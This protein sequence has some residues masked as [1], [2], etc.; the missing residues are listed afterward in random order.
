MKILFVNSCIRDNSRTKLIA[1][2]FIKKILSENS[3]AELKE[4]VLQ[5]LAM[6]P[7]T[8]KTLQKRDALSAN[9]DYQN[10]FFALA[11]EFAAADKIIIA[12]P[13]YDL[14]FPALLK[15][16]LEN[17]CVCGI[18][19]KYS[20]EGIPVGLCK[21]KELIYITTVGGYI[22]QYNFGF[23]YLKGLCQMFG[24]EKQKQIA[25]EGLDIWGN[26]AEAIVEDV[27]KKENLI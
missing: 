9:K 12:A 25:A 6:E 18:T 27:I 17:V 16:Y 20:E 24:I 23:E 11:N 2:K 14:Q 7:L 13:Y 3:G 26:D 22:G 4:L 10:D 8:E 1:D 5:D 19:F 21:A 15:V